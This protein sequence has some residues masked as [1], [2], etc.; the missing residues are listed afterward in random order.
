MQHRQYVA[1]FMGQK[2]MVHDGP[3]VFGTSYILGHK[4]ASTLK[5][6]ARAAQQQSELMRRD[7]VGR[8]DGWQQSGTPSGAIYA[9]LKYSGFRN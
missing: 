8:P 5:N 1:I 6:P 4:P 3:S 9:I 7:A 2:P